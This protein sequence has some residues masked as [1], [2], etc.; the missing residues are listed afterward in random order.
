[1][2]DDRM[3]LAKY[4]ARRS[5]PQTLERRPT[6]GRCW[7]AAVTCY[8]HLVKPFV[9]PIQ[10]VILQ[11]PSEWGNPIATARMAHLS[12]TNSEV[13]VGYN[14]GDDARVESLLSAPGC[15]NV[16]LFPRRDALPLEDVLETAAAPDAER[17]VLWVLDCKWSHTSKI[18]RLSP[19]VAKLPATAFVPDAPSRFC[20][21][22]Q[23]GPACVST[24][25]AIHAVL[26]RRAALAGDGDVR[27]DGMLEVFRH[28]VSQ[29]LGFCDRDDDTRHSEAKRKRRQKNARRQLQENS[30]G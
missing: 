18:M 24:V 6:C 12:M 3:T 27:H 1:M 13:V 15:R 16:M 7:K 14:F 20:V 5:P 28:L 26:A 22:T 19:S 11:N 30:A 23:P 9:S 21:R 8:C 29:Q 4:L 2:T 25:E 10:F 17:L